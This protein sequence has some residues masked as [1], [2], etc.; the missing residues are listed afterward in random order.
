M[1]AFDFKQDAMYRY[2]ATNRVQAD[3]N[4]GARN[5]A[6]TYA[7]DANTNLAI[8]DAVVNDVSIAMQRVLMRDR[9]VRLLLQLI[10]R[11]ARFAV[12]L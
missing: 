11:P 5:S 4:I 6:V 9:L 12:S 1:Y 8:L 10:P 3:V 2:N 7:T